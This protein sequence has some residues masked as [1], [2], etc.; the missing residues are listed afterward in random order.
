MRPTQQLFHFLTE[1]MSMT[2]IYQ[3]AVI[4]H[5]LEHGG[6]ASKQDLARTLSGHDR[7]VQEYYEKV[8]M[9][10]P[11]ATLMKHGVVSYDRKEKVFSLAFDLSDEDAIAE[12]KT[13]CEIKIAEWIQ[14]KAERDPSGGVEAS[15]RYRVLKAARGRCELCGVS[16]KLSPIDV[17]HVVP[18]NHADKH[19]FVVKDGTRMP[20]DDERNL[21]ALCFRCNRAKRDKDKTDF[22]LPQQKLVRDKIPDIIEASG[23]TPV[24]RP[25]EGRELIDRLLEKLLEEHVELL[26]SESIDELVDMIEVLFALAKQLGESEEAV[27]VRRMVKREERGDFDQALFLSQIL[28]RPPRCLRASSGP[29][30]V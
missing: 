20:L 13:I 9:R 10:W 28:L 23:R 19:G 21:Q 24:T 1:T 18:R 25:L 17:D 15:T 3:P 12:A 16:S 8:L 2:D 26:A 14:K 29:A 27:L 4:L 7:S 5:L 30:P 6:T 11:K 22:R